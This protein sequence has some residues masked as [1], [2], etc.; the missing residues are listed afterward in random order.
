MY[1]GLQLQESFICVVD[2]ICV[3]ESLCFLQSTCVTV[4]QLSG[5]IVSQPLQPVPLL[6]LWPCY[7]TMPGSISRESLLGIQSLLKENHCLPLLQPETWKTVKALGI[8]RHKATHRG[9]RA[10]RHIRRKIPVIT[11]HQGHQGQ[12]PSPWPQHGCSVNKQHTNL[13]PVLL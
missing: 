2:F 13:R 11:G 5:A 1:K 10:G 9:F 12:W 4:N 3:C 7:V 8:N 6:G